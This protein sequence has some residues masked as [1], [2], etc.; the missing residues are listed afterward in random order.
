MAD[1]TD[2]A[3]NGAVAL[4]D[5]AAGCSPVSRPTMFRTDPPFDRPAGNTGEKP[6]V[7]HG[8]HRIF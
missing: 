1:P 6:K 5:G 8:P 7:N 4:R 3:R 2:A